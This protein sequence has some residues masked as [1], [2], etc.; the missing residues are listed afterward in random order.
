MSALLLVHAGLG[1]VALLAGAV[2]LGARKGS[3]THIRAGTL[4]FFA[5]TTA[6]T[7]AI[8]IIVARDNVFLGLLAPFTLWML[9]SGWRA[10][11]RSRDAGGAM[12]VID[13]G[14]NVV[15]LV[16]ALGLVVLGAVTLARSGEV[17]GFG[18]VALGLGAL[19]MRLTWR[20]LR[21]PDDE[22]RHAMLR[23]HLGA[24]GGAYVAAVTAFSAVNF[25]TDVFPPVL[26]WL[27]PPTVGVVGLTWVARRYP[28]QDGS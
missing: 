10:P 25:P 18:T 28:L 20:A 16:G 24:M 3:P 9:W 15:G 14:V 21:R 1:G 5:M 8:P 27:V 11:R 2:A 26:V 22:S 7:V 23:A 4:F 13:R 19:G 12:R 6:I 17:I